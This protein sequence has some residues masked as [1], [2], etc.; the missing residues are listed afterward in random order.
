MAS[1]SGALATKAVMEESRL[2]GK[3]I[4]YGTPAEE[5][6]SSLRVLHYSVLATKVWLFAK[7]HVSTYKRSKNAYFALSYSHF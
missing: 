3:V 6:R 7:A 5:G 1:L 4:L 2:S